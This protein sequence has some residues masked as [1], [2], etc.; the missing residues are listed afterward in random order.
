[1]PI[2]VGHG[3]DGSD[4]AGQII[5]Q[6]GQANLSRE[7]QERLAASQQRHQQ[8]M[9]EEQI[10]AQREAQGK[11]ESHADR[12]AAI[13]LSAQQ[14]ENQQRI[15][16][17]KAKAEFDAANFEKRY[18]TRQKAEIARIKKA[19]VD[20]ANNPDFTDDEKKKGDHIL[21]LQELGYKPSDLPKLSPHPK[22][23]DIGDVWSHKESG[24]LITRGADGRAHVLVRPD[25]T[26]EYKKAEGLNKIHQA[27]ITRQHNQEKATATLRAKMLFDETTVMDK[28]GKST[29]QR[30]LRKPEEIDAIMQ[31]YSG[32]KPKADPKQQ[33][34]DQELIEK[35]M[36]KYG[37]FSHVPVELQ[38]Q[39]REA[40]KRLGGSQP[41]Q[42]DRKEYPQSPGEPVQ[43]TEKDDNWEVDPSVA[44]GSE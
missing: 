39:L 23:Q 7:Q 36:Q 6:A 32:Q 26:I 2:T 28:D 4:T 21:A 1:M 19:R 18:T 30:R 35:T 31:A 34:S 13:N 42:G 33:Q 9:Q 16:E 37:G 15:A 5:A 40:V 22:G 8:E 41:Q 11:S 20:L 10:E 3:G 29:K 25:Q 38:K 27:E 17:I 44:E 43:D 12:Q 24:A 14:I